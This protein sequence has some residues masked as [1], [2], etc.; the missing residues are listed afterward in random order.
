MNACWSWRKCSISINSGDQVRD[1]GVA[2]PKPR[3]QTQFLPSIRWRK[4]KSRRVRKI[5]Q[6][7]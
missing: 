1:G 6:I 4:R 2:L 7:A 3:S 5:Q